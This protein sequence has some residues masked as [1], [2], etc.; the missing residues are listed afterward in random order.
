VKTGA[1]TMKKLGLILL[2]FLCALSSGRA[3]LGD[4]EAEAARHYGEPVNH[5]AN[6][7]QDK[8]TR[9]YEYH[10]YRVIVTFEQGRSTSEGFFLLGGTGP[11]ADGTIQALLQEHAAGQSWRELPTPTGVRLWIRPGAIATYGEEHGKAQFAVMAYSGPP[12]DVIN[13]A[14]AHALVTPPP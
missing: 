10:G 8:Q 1:G 3:L 6:T 7:Q 12:Q 13:A 14:A 11:M 4:D 5:T 9:I 2:G